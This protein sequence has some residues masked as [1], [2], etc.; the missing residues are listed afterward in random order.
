MGSSAQ[1]TPSESRIYV[2]PNDNG[3]ATGSA[4]ADDIYAFG[5]GETLVGNG[6][7]DIFHIGTNTDAVI[8]ETD[9][10][11]S[12]VETWA[13]SYVLPDSVDN[14]VALGDYAH[15]LVGNA[16][17]NFIT[18]VRNGGSVDGGAGDDV[19]DGGSVTALG[20]TFIYRH[21]GGNDR[22]INFDT[23]LGSTFGVADDHVKLVDTGFTSFDQVK[24][25]M[26][27]FTETVNG[28][29]ITSVRLAMSDASGSIV[30]QNHHVA[31]FVVAENFTFDNSGVTPA[32]TPAPA[33]VPT[34]T[35]ATG[36]GGFVHPTS[37]GL[38]VLVSEDAFNGDAQFTV[39]IDGVQVVGPT[40]VTTLHSS[41]QFE[42]FHFLTGI[43]APDAPH[44]VAVHFINDAWGGS[45]DA[46]RNLYVEGIKF[47]NVAADGQT[48]Q[49]DA[50]FGD[51]AFDPNAA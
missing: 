45:P 31:D 3:M 32:P 35:P 30:F 40:S 38:D 12:T 46:D 25:A 39:D 33:P 9:P 20:E 24:A 16:A 21:G 41:G 18:N 14:L 50:N 48:A 34:P 28:Q 42:D 4:G 10:G 49:N 27:E 29:T 23:V 43:S 19:I 6:G 8:V 44:T 15:T 7:D 1:L 22:W 11:T 26:T 13:S 17:A 36:G 47:G 5:P 51:A 2:G 37:I